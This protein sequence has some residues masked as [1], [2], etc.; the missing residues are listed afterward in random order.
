MKSNLKDPGVVLYLYHG[1]HREKGEGR[2][3]RPLK[4]GIWLLSAV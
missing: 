3:E 1:G 4:H 2:N